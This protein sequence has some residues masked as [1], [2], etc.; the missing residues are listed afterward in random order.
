MDMF[1]E[2]AKWD[3]D[4]KHMDFLTIP[5]SSSGK[6]SLESGSYYSEKR[7][8]NL[9]G[10]S[11]THPLYILKQ[12]ILKKNDGDRNFTDSEIAGHFRKD[13]ESIKRLM[14]NLASQG[15]LI[16]NIE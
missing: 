14:V 2:W 10:L 9:Q 13:I 7:F 3:I 15:F 5:G 6:M 1:I 16:Y 11:D 4:T 12:F 8:M